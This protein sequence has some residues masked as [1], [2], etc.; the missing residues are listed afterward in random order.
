MRTQ[1]PFPRREADALRAAIAAGGLQELGAPSRD[2]EDPLDREGR[3]D[4]EGAFSLVQWVIDAIP[5]PVYFQDPEGR[6]LACNRAFERFSG[7]RHEQLVGRFSRDLLPESPR[8]SGIDG[9][10]GL[11]EGSGAREYQSEFQ[12]ADGAVHEVVIYTAAL[13]DGDGF[14][15]G[16]VGVIVDVSERNRAERRL[17]ESEARFRGLASQP[18]VGIVLIEDGRI[19]YS[20]AR[21]DEMFGYCAHEIRE[22]GPL[23]LTHEDD[24][25]VV[26]QSIRRRE[27]GESDQVDS[28]FRGVRK[29]GSVIDIECHGGVMNIAGKSVLVSLM[30]DITE[31]TRAERA[32]QD[33]Q[34]RLRDEATLD[35]LT[36][37]HNRG[38]LEDALHRE[39]ILAARAHRPVSVIIA[40][41][42]H[43]KAV[44]DRFG[45]L[46]GDEALRGFGALL[47][48]HARGSDIA[49]RYGGDEFVLVL[50][51]MPAANA[52]QRAEQLRRELALPPSEEARS[53]VVVTASFGIA[54]F[55]H[56]GHSVEELIA[57]ADRALYAAKTT[58]RDRVTPTS[59]P[60]PTTST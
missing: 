14:G 43:F 11:R 42:D 40:D 60:P 38:Y 21:F 31:R 8:E 7:R 32:A 30:S 56:D 13:R 19:T 6:L 49:C 51:G 52:A 9:E 22:L 45:H 39:L 53:R 47:A 12:S 28:V 34:E 59:D 20:N 16:V 41:I 37:L 33:L 54:T 26:A 46:A 1:E 18:L 36:G 29:D 15:A 50:P 27:S 17:R 4:G 35:A 3:W 2:R 48:R 5:T 44:N 23:G 24:R 58:G 25:A 10:V 55:P 57:A